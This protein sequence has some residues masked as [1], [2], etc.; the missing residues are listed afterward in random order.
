MPNS[1]RKSPLALCLPLLCSCAFSAQSQ[2]RAL[3]IGINH[4]QDPGI[5]SLVGARNDL[6]AFH[7]MLVQQLGFKEGEIKE[8]QDQEA[9]RAGVLK[10]I[11][12][13]LIQGSAPGGRV[14]LYYSGHGD[15]VPDQTGAGQDEE[16]HLDEAW[17]A[18]DAILATHENYI[19]DDEINAKIQMLQGREVLAVIDSCHSGTALR[20]AENNEDAKMPRWENLG[21]DKA[22]KLD[23]AHQKEGG[24]IDYAKLG[25]VA[26][27]KDTNPHI[28][29]FFAVS[30][31][32]L[33][34]EDKLD[35]ARPHSVFTQAFV[36]GLSDKKADKNHDGQV[37]FA[38]LFA[39]VRQRSNT[40]CVENL[41][42][43]QMG[44]TPGLES[45]AAKAG[46]DFLKFGSH[47]ATLPVPPA[48][49]VEAIL[50][51]NNE[52]QLSLS[53]E[54][55][56][57][58]R[59]ND[60]VRYQFHTQRAGKLVIFDLDANGKL[61][62]I[63]PYPVAPNAPRECQKS[64]A[65]ADW[66]P[67]GQTLRLPDNCMGLQFSAQEPLGK[68]KVVAVLIE[69]KDVDTRNLIAIQKGARSPAPQGLAEHPDGPQWMWD[70][71]AALDQVIHEKDGKNR[72]ARWS[73]VTADYEITR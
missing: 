30:P 16:D 45:E 49:I 25:G 32:Q 70:L 73:M 41:K 51:P 10:G 44:L 54:P 56:G 57:P 47:Q 28:A 22:V 50:P 66:T 21:K 59:L 15:Q 11:D 1:P 20:A 63:F 46:E 43:C 13:W 5:R 40:Y 71:R 17:V 34:L 38:E 33:A 23:L 37:F 27:G 9:T 42:K 4:Y 8:L 18:Q 65:I 19:L 39:Y 14:V 48:Q 60:K 31:N 26:N 12:E 72:E 58:L 6:Q 2:D 36:D 35:Q 53:I 3:L 69:D 64:L 67:A 61:T 7:Q 29:A 68:G 55:S 52:A 24:F 62:Q